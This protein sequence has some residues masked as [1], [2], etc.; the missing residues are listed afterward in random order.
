M[1]DKISTVKLLCHFS[2]HSSYGL[3]L[4]SSDTETKTRVPCSCFFPRPMYKAWR[5]VVV[6][7]GWYHWCYR[8]LEVALMGSVLERFIAH[9]FWREGE[10]PKLNKVGW[11]FFGFFL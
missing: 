5:G 7:A 11:L 8:L 9:S 3:A 2:I 1:I 6:T 10:Q 4:H